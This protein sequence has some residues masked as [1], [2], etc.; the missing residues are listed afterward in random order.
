M[1]RWRSGVLNIRFTFREKI[2]KIMDQNS[3]NCSVRLE[4]GCSKTRYESDVKNRKTEADPEKSDWT[5]FKWSA[6]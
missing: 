1:I 3:L 4:K 6:M 5:E 2:S